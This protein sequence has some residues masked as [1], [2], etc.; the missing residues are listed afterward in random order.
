M[1]QKLQ[2][3]ICYFFDFIMK[4]QILITQKPNSERPAA[5]SNFELNQPTSNNQHFPQFSPKCK[6][7]SIFLLSEPLSVE[8]RA[9]ELKNN[10]I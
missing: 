4:T 10:N 6:C 1:S 7:C 5:I 8:T 9:K 2:Y 3:L